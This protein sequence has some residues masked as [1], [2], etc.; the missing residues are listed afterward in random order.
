[1]R[2]ATL[3]AVA[4]LVTVVS[5]GLVSTGLG[6]TPKSPTGG[7]KAMLGVW[8]PEKAVMAGQEFPDEVCKS[9]RMVLS[10]GKY[11]VTVGD[12]VDEGTYT[13]DE[14]KSPKTITIVGV[15]GPNKGKTFLGIYELD[16]ETLKVCYDLSGKA[17][18]T[19][20]ESKPDTPLF[21]ASY[22]RQKSQHHPIRKTSAGVR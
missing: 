12:K 1:M 15:K 8:T 11:V 19:S 22:R 5:T 4:S 10:D 21:L 14:T 9:I 6:A 2:S 3:I 7:A 20:F 18:P 16:H 13:I 17:L